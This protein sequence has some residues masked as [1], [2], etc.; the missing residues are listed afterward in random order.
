MVG[1]LIPD[2]ARETWV[3][4]R[5]GR[6]RVLAGGS[7]SGLPP[8]FLVHGGGTDNAGISWF[9]SFGPLAA[10]RRVHAVDL[11][12][13]GGSIDVPAAGGPR[14]LAAVVAEVMERLGT[15]PSVVFG[16]SMGGDVALNLALARPDLVAGLVL[17]AP[18]GLVPLLRDRRTQYWAWLAAQAPDWLLLPAA[19]I[20]NRFVGSALKAIVRDP[21]T[22]P[23]EVV[24]EFTREAREPLGGIAYGRYNQATLGRH[25]MLNDVSGQV[26]GIAVPALFFHGED[27]P[28]VDPEGSRR[29]ASA[30]PHAD[31]ELVAGCGH[32]AQLEAHD[33]FLATTAAFLARLDG[34][35]TSH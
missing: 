26:A 16:V 21:S 20:A 35:R 18:G 23:P 6:L 17:V 22:L 10:H 3:Q 2:G 8:A 19:R 27:D 31:L 9:R 12:G 4:A 30:M 11:P 15:G 24:A 1:R 14:Q 32:L 5:S 7:D 28:L 34:R 13:F 29:A 25:G 33:R